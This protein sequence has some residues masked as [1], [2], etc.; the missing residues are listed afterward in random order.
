MSNATAPATLSS[1]SVALR[2]LL[3]SDAEWCYLLACGP[4]GERW[5]YRGRTPS[6][7]QVA[8]DLW[9]G[10]YAQFVVVDRATGT[11]AGLVGFY[12]VAVDAG[13]AYAFALADPQRS[14]QVTEGFGLLCEWGFDHQ[15]FQRVYLEVPEFN[16][17][18]FTSLGDAAV[19][20]GRLRNH[21]IWQ[22]RYWDYFILVLTPESFR[23]H[24]AALLERRRADSVDT[25]GAGA[26]AE[27]V[28]SLWP[29]DSLGLVEVADALEQV[30]GT[31]VDS[32][33][34]VSLEAPDPRTWAERSLVVAAQPL[35]NAESPPAE[36]SGPATS[37]R[38]PRS[39]RTTT[40]GDGPEPQSTV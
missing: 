27:L 3:P 26:Y 28:E 19:V 5:R 37:S 17:G 2:P 24:F 31:T 13:R 11:R 12:N 9:R 35:G 16:L 18:Q 4:A 32:T 40:T 39:S 33:Q 21:E 30:L 36:P 14:T 10:V 6:H 8:V 20:E 34:L 1:R 23:T 25:M 15:G 29:L 7:E 22:G 38:A